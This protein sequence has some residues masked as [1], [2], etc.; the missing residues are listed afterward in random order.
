[1]AFYSFDYLYKYI[2][3]VKLINHLEENYGLSFQEII[4]F[5][6]VFS[7]NLLGLSIGLTTKKVLFKGKRDMNRIKRCKSCN[8][9]I[10]R[11]DLK[12]FKGTDDLVCMNCNTKPN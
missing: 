4:D 7:I 2:D 8:F 10:E 1:M 3:L 6:S 9:P 5:P 12:I 11:S